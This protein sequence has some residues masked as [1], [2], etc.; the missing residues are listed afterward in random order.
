MQK[1]C[2]HQSKSSFRS[3]EVARST[4]QTIQIALLLFIKYE[5]LVENNL[6]RKHNSLIQKSSWVVE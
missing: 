3:I 2:R 5:I 4:Q 1:Q 6:N